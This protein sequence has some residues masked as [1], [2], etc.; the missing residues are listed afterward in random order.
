MSTYAAALAYRGLFALFPFLIFV[1]ALINTLDVDPPLAA[2]AEWSRSDGT[3]R[4]PSAIR[5]WLVM[6]ARARAEGPAIAVAAGAAVWVVATGARVLRRALDVAANAPHRGGAW[7]RLAWSMAVAPLLGAAIVMAMLLLTFTRRS[8]QDLARSAGVND[9]I[10]EL[11]DWIRM[12]AGLVLAV[13]IIAFVYRF[14]SSHRIGFRAGIRGAVIA[15]ALWILVSIAFASALSG[16]SRYGGTYGSF[17]AAI[18][19]LVYLYLAAAAVLF[20]AEV[21]AVIADAAPASTSNRERDR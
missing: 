17:S 16:V 5:Q 9:L 10:V 6:Q 7:R 4:L 19:L 11:W 20:G 8:I 12:P 3:G 21:N 1:I 15:A 18:V 14:A 2:V 13:A